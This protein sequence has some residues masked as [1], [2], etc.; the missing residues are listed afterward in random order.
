M[1]DER[2]LVRIK[3]ADEDDDKYTDNVMAEPGAEYEVKIFFYNDVDPSLN[4]VNGYDAYAQ[5]IRVKVDNIAASIT[6]GQSAMIKGTVT[7][8]NTTPEEVWDTAFIQTDQTVALRY[9][10][11]SARIHTAR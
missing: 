10:R 8:T 5:N 7:A 3:K 1:G 6:K 2:N 4:D 9:I 11:G